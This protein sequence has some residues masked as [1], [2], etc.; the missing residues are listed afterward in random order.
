[1]KLRLLFLLCVLPAQAFAAC[2]FTSNMT[3][4]PVIHPSLIDNPSIPP[5]EIEATSVIRGA[6]G[7]ASC[8]ALGFLSVQIKWPRGTGY[9]LD[10]IG[11]EYRVVDGAAPEGL[12]PEGVVTSPVNGRKAEHQFTWHDLL[13]PEQ[14]PIRL[15]LEVRAVTRDS[16]RGAPVRVAV[17]Q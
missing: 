12:I 7:G 14:R 5:P 13:P 3:P 2:L 10:E 4:F 11:F 16:Q 15:M 9:D 1:M 6:G 8:D 17:T